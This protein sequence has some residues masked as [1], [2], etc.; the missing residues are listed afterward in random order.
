MPAGLS[1]VERRRAAEDLADRF[2]RNH[3]SEDITFL[4]TNRECEAEFLA[5][6]KL[7]MSHRDTDMMED[8][9]LVFTG[10]ELVTHSKKLEW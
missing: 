5:I 4:F 10:Y 9:V 3:S 1:D 2:R 7:A 8:H 6:G